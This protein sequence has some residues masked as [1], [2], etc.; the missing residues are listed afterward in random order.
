MKNTFLSLAIFSIAISLVISSW[1][2]SNSL[3][4][5]KTNHTIQDENQ[6]Q[7]LTK[8]EVADY[9]GISV[10]EVQQLTE[11]PEGEGVTAS[12]IP[13]IKIKKINY[14]PKKAIDKWLVNAEFITVP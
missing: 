4:D 5:K 14:Y 3:S 8:S 9:L 2:L 11:V 13:H 6:H 1:L 7:L 10:E 12:Y